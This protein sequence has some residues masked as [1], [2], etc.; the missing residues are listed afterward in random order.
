MKDI[1]WF[2]WNSSD[3]IKPTYVTLCK[4]F[5]IY[6]WEEAEI[7]LLND[8]NIS[9]YL[10][11]IKQKVAGIE[12]DVKGRLDRLFRKFKNKNLMKL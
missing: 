5:I 7:I 9:D 2:Y 3:D 10:P 12:I 8:K 4:W 11:G 1:I 6:K